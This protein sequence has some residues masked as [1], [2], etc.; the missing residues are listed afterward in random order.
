M[1]WTVVLFLV[2]V[3]LWIGPGFL[4]NLILALAFLVWIGS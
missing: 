3:R 4:S 1:F 2:F